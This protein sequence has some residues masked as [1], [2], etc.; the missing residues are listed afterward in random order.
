MKARTKTKWALA[1]GAALAL[2]AGRAEAA[3]PAFLNIDVTI[4]AALSVAVN[5]VASSTDSSVSWAGTPNQQ[6]V[7]S[8][9]TTVTNDTG[10]LSEKWK[11]S[12][13]ASSLDTTGGGQTWALGT[14]STT[15]GADTFAIQAVFGSS[16][17]ASCL[18]ANAATWDDST[19][20]PLLTSGAG[21]QYS[22]TVFAAA[23]L[24]NN[25]DHRP[26][27]LA[28]GLM[29][30]GSKRALC[31]RAIMPQ[32]TSTTNKQNIQVIVTAL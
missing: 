24:N 10:I 18:A 29:F 9:T 30:A 5:G 20:A 19:A 27:V 3:N 21:V 12:T 17:T 15:V 7:Q 26:D 6:F 14:S 1:L 16:N 23:A 2:W 25:G 11:L 22:Q 32:S 31:W 28:S 13:N 8:G 4:T